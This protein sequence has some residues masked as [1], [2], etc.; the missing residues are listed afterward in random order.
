MSI[1]KGK[2]QELQQCCCIFA[3]SVQQVLILKSGIEISGCKIEVDKY[4][5]SVLLLEAGGERTFF[6]TGRAGVKQHCAVSSCKRCLHR[7]LHSPDKSHPM[8]LLIPK[9]AHGT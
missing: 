7:N 6:V 5:L 8:F 9:R 1:V 3:P 4:V 2:Q